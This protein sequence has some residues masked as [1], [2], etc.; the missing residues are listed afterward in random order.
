MRSEHVLHIPHGGCLEAKKGSRECALNAEDRKVVDAILAEVKETKGIAQKTDNVLRSLSVSL[1]GSA[2]GT[3]YD[4]TG[5]RLGR[6]EAD[7][8]NLKDWRT[9]AMISIITTLAGI[10]GFLIKLYIEHHP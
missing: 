2:N 10:A 3:V 4:S 8:V 5:G 6:V 7:V 1:I 9:W